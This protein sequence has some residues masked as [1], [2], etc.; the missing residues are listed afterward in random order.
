MRLS[1]DRSLG[2]TS[3]WNS[4]PYSIV[5]LP[6]RPSITIERWC[7]SSSVCDCKHFDSESDRDL[8]VWRR[9]FHLL[10]CR[11]LTPSIIE[12]DVPWWS[13]TRCWQSPLPRSLQP[14]RLKMNSTRHSWITVASTRRFSSTYSQRSNH[15]T[16]WPKHLCDILLWL[17]DL[18]CF[19]DEIIMM[20]KHEPNQR[21]EQDEVKEML[22]NEQECL[23]MSLEAGFV[24]MRANFND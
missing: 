9:C 5:Y 10:G 21:C 15:S 20:I 17:C 14:Y 2:G 18:Y 19:V 7:F 22:R 24:T 3:S 23:R 12:I 1:I 13:F 6:P 16:R 8:F 4:Q 11:V